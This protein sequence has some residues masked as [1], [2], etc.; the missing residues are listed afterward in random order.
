MVS[1]R[2]LL[3]DFSLDPHRSFSVATVDD[4]ALKLWDFRQQNF[5]L[6]P[7]THVPQA[8][9]SAT[10]SVC[11]DQHT[12]LRVVTGGEDAAIRVWDLRKPDVPILEVEHRHAHSHWLRST[13]FNP[14]HSELLL[15][16]SSD[17]SMRLWR[18]GKNSL[19]PLGTTYAF[20]DS[21]EMVEWSDGWTFAGL[22]YEGAVVIG[23]VPLEEKYRILL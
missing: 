15:S 8:H 12:P 4:T 5:S 10:R 7:V 17:G 3:F 22:S 14:F 16:G 21:V 6:N 11:F 13:K 18:A 9:R 19:K 23:R 1:E 2:D 20:E